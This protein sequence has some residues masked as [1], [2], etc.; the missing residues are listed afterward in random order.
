MAEKTS[1]SLS[2][3]FEHPNNALSANHA[4]A[5]TA[6]G[7]LVQNLR[8]SN[9]KTKTRNSAEIKA[10]MLLQYLGYEDFKPTRYS[11]VWYYLVK[12]D[13]DNTVT[14]CK[15]LLDG[16]CNAFGINDRDLDIASVQRIK[17][18]QKSMQKLVTITFY[19]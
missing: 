13:A 5:L 3:N 15:A 14:R 17:A 19:E 1:R 4:R 8:I 2:I 9:I 10:R 7:A 6:R 18:P 12:P 16:C 11:I